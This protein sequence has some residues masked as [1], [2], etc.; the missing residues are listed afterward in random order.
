MAGERRRLTACRGEGG[1][2]VLTRVGA[3]GQR[4]KAAAQSREG[5]R[6]CGRL[7]G[8]DQGIFLF[9]GNQEL[10]L[11]SVD[12]WFIVLINLVPDK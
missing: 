10:I 9:P 12:K 1:D 5:E 4:E 8:R 2:R 6:A 3:C 11:S 7:H